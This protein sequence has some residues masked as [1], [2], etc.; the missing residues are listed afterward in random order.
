MKETH[1]V[2]DEYRKCNKTIRKTMK[3]AKEQWIDDKCTAIEDNL[4]KH[5]SKEAYK[6]VKYL[7]TDR[8]SKVSTIQDKR[9]NCLTEE[10]KIMK[11][12]TEYCTELYK[13]SSHGR[14]YRTEGLQRESRDTT[15][16]SPK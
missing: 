11:R 15:P 9:G 4:T 13:S 6:V 5:N 12:W 3:A 7:T 8:K 16:N 2:A 10:D 14:H 1:S